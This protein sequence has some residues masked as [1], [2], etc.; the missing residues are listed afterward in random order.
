MKGKAWIT[1]TKQYFALNR[2]QRCKFMI[3]LRGPFSRAEICEFLD[4]K[5]STIHGWE[6][7]G[8]LPRSEHLRSMLQHFQD[9]YVEQGVPGSLRKALDEID[10]IK[11]LTTGKKPDKKPVVYAEQET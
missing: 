1:G 11:S 10:E 8:K 9:W 6:T 2:E 5:R 3:L 7:L 4:L